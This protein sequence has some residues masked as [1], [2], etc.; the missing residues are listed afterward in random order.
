MKLTGDI[1]ACKSFEYEVYAMA[2]NG[3][4]VNLIKL[5]WK[6][7]WNH[8]KEIYLF[9]EGF[10]YLEPLCMVA[11]AAHSGKLYDP[12]SDGQSFSLLIG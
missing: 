11:A 3:N 4:Q 10:S 12:Q 9:R 8:T 6:N 1:Y 5:A 7:L 2:E